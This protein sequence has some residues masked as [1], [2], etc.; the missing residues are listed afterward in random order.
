MASEWKPGLIDPYQA[1]SS[2]PRLNGASFQR[3]GETLKPA[4]RLPIGGAANDSIERR[5][6]E[7]ALRDSEER[8]RGY[9]E[10]GLVGMA[11]TSPAKG[12]L[13]VNQKLCDILGYERRELVMMDWATLTHPDDLA[14]SVARF[15]R[16]MSGEINGYSLDKRWIRKDG[17]V[18]DS[19]ISVKCKRKPDGSVAYLDALLLDISPRKRA[20]AEARQ[21]LERIDLAF[22]GS[23]F[24][25]WDWWD[26]SDPACHWWS[27]RICQ[28][29]GFE[30]SEVTPSFDAFMDSVHPGDRSRVAGAVKD[31]VEGT[32]GRLDVEFRIQVGAMRSRWFRSKGHP[33]RDTAG[34]VVRLIGVFEDIDE[35]KRAQESLKESE[36]RYRALLEQTATGIYVIQDEQ[37]AYVNPRMRE[38]FGYGEDEYFDPDP[39]THVAPEDRAVAAQQMRLRIQDGVQASYSIRC[40]RKDGTRF[41]MGLNARRASYGGRPAIMAVAQDVTEKVRVDE[42]RLGRLARYQAQIAGVAEVSASDALVTGNFEKLARKVTE[43]ACQVTGVERANVWVF[44]QAENELHCIDLFEAGP[45]RHSAGMV[46]AET[47]FAKEFAAL[48]TTRYVDANEPLTDAR[49]SGYAEDYLRP[50]RISSMLDAVIQFSDRRLGLLCLEHIDKPH[51]WENDEITFATQLAD[52]LAIAMVNRARHEADA[53]LRTSLENS[54]TAIAATVEMRDPYTAGHERRVAE[55]ATAIARHMGLSERIVEGIHFGAM[56]HD[57]GKIQVPAE[58]LSKPSRLT[59]LEYELIKVHAQ[60][61]YEILKGIEFPW[62]VAQMVLQH[63]ERADGS[64]YPQQLKGDA[65]ILEARILAVADTVEAMASHRPYRP[66]LGLE[67]A[68]AEIERGSGTAYDGEVAK[69]CLSLFREQGYVLPL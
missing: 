4:E 37:L 55:L 54:I 21:A 34:K 7:H 60:S 39:S 26:V 10:L 44:N 57:L 19:R 16:L 15:E 50:L 65:I 32:T 11:I 12:F 6:T 66:G 2:R 27:T 41:T 30:P 58:I 52:K 31:A 56:I 22:E 28:L 5:A 23:G 49:T 68:L 24:G 36:A 69:C 17:K 45:A 40:R 42:E 38:I 1:G 47:Q 14:A 62:P 29:L 18:V 64:G 3:R 35:R 59:N 43:I 20:E 8:F 9:F 63:H 61:G 51:R 33:I 25:V 46:L 53:K 13:E 67:K 48:K